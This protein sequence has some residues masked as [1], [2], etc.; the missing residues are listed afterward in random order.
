MKNTKVCVV[1]KCEREPLKEIEAES[2]WT[3]KKFFCPKC[4]RGYGVVTKTG[5][6]TQVATLVTASVILA[7]FTLGVVGGMFLGDAGDMDL[8]IEDVD[9]S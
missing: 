7:N 1:A 8:G 6:A 2:T 3:M 5:K 4:G 9:V